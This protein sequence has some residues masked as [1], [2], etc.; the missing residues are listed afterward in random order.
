MFR[1]ARESGRHPSYARMNSNNKPKI[2]EVGIGNKQRIFLLRH[3]GYLPANYSVAEAQQR[4]ADKQTITAIV[5][6][7]L[8]FSPGQKIFDKLINPI[9]RRFMDTSVDTSP[10][11]IIYE[12][13]RSNDGT[14]QLHPVACFVAEEAD[15]HITTHFIG[16]TQEARRSTLLP[17]MLNE[18]L[19]YAERSDK[20]IIFSNIV[21]TELLYTFE[22]DI[23][24]RAAQRRGFGI[25]FSQAFPGTDVIL[26]RQPHGHDPR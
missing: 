17:I 8:S 13:G 12:V 24:N 21:N 20:N 6:N 18:I 5:H 19:G 25:Q 9:P 15:K 2:I 14:K 11:F 23:V 7:S 1:N 10:S 3:A 26:R 22:K 4:N 16:I